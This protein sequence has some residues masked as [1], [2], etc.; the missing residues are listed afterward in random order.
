MSQDQPPSYG[1]QPQQPQPYQPQSYRPQPY[2]QW[3]PG[4]RPLLSTQQK[5]IIT[6]ICGAAAVVVIGAAASAITSKSGT[7]HHHSAA[8]PVVA[9][10][11][12]ATPGP[13]TTK[14]AASKAEELADRI[15]TW[16]HG[17]GGKDEARLISLLNAVVS[18]TSSQNLP[19]TEHA[20]ARLAAGVTAALAAPEIPDP[21]AA[22]NYAA[23]L[24]QYST[25]ATDCQD[26]ISSGDI[27]LIST[28]SQHL[29]TGTSDFKKATARI[30]TIADN[31]GR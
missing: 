21:V 24:A 11:H 20:C 3:P 5:A 15:T 25:G 18:A 16:D 9:V 31:A 28:G 30:D 8:A 26:G 1:G 2:G 29:N 6:I 23:G 22:K 7:V 12:P 10:T 14:P 4:Q 19:A 17:P 13:S 27:T